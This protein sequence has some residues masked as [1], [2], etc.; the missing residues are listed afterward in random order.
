MRV[1]VKLL[2]RTLDGEPYVYVLDTEMVSDWLRVLVGDALCL[3]ND[4]DGV[5]LNVMLTE[6]LSEEVSL[7]SL[8]CDRESVLVMDALE[9]S[10]CVVVADRVELG[11]SDG[12]LDS[13][14]VFVSLHSLVRLPSLRLPV[15]VAEGVR[16]SPNLVRLIDSSSV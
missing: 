1:S 4:R 5:T 6:K 3:V 8:L 10:V 12:E 13:V 14:I 9:L 15:H 2:L 7:V 11:V 16:E